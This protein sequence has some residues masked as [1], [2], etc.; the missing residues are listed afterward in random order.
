[1]IRVRPYVPD[2]RA[3]MLSLA[4]RLIIGMPA[5]RDPQLSITAVQGWITG[6]IDRYGQTTMIFVA[7]DDQ[8]ERLGFATVTHETHFTGEHQAYIGELATSEAAEG[9]GAGKALVQACEDWARDQGYRV[10]SLATG[11]ANTRALGF[12]H[13]LG[14]RDEDVKLVKLL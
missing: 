1:M 7:E 11:A 13:Y 6:S 5:W 12:Y 8:A 3:F 4:P 14:F 10:L 2:D 9:C